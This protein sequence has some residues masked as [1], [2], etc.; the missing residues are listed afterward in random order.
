MSFR[1]LNL[2]DFVRSIMHID[3]DTFIYNP[4]YLID[5]ETI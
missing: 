4:L 2:F 3:Y 5:Y 1:M